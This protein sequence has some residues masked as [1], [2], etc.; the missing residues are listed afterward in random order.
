[1]PPPLPPLQYQP[2]S[3]STANETTPV[4]SLLACDKERDACAMQSG[5]R[6]R[7]PPSTSNKGAATQ[8]THLRCA[9]YP[10][11][12][13]HGSN[14]TQ[15][16]TN[17]VAQSSTNF[18]KS[19]NTTQKSNT[20]AQDNLNAIQ[21]S[22]NIKAVQDNSNDPS[23]NMAQNSLN[24][25]QSSSNCVQS[26]LNS[27]KSVQTSPSTTQNNSYNTHSRTDNNESS[28]DIAQNNSDN[29]NNTDINYSSSEIIQ[30]RSD[31]DQ[32]SFDITENGF[33]IAQSSSNNA[34]FNSNATQ[35]SSN[36]CGTNFQSIS[37]TQNSSFCNS[38]N[39]HN[40]NRSSIN[41]ISSSNVQSNVCYTPNSSSVLQ[42]SSNFSQNSSNCPQSSSNYSQSNSNYS[43]SNSNYSQSSSTNPQSSSNFPQGNSGF[44]S[45]N[46]SQGN[47]SSNFAGSNFTQS[48]TDTSPSNFII[49][50]YQNSPFQASTNFQGGSASGFIQGG[51]F[52][53]NGYVQQNVPHVYL[54]NN[55]HYSSRQAT[56]PPYPQQHCFGMGN[57]YGYGGGIYPCS[58]FYRDGGSQQ[59]ER[60]RGSTEE[61]MTTWSKK[62]HS[63]SNVKGSNSKSTKGMNRGNKGGGCESS[64]S[65]EL[66]R[67]RGLNSIESDRTRGS[68]CTREMKKKIDIC[69]FRSNSVEGLNSTNLN[70]DKL[71]TT[72][73]SNTAR[74]LDLDS[75][76]DQNNSARGGLNATLGG[77]RSV[78][79]SP[80][81]ENENERNHKCDNKSSH[82]DQSVFSGG[83]IKTYNNNRY[84]RGSSQQRLGRGNGRVY[85]NNTQRRLVQSG[86][87]NSSQ[88]LSET[89]TK[90]PC[91]DVLSSA[92]S[93]SPNNLIPDC[94]NT[95]NNANGIA[96]NDELDSKP[97]CVL[98]SRSNMVNS[99][100]KNPEDEM[101]SCVKIKNKNDEDLKNIEYSVV[102][103]KNCIHI[104]N[105][106]EEIKRCIEIKNKEYTDIKNKDSIEIKNKEHV[107]V[108]NKK[109][110]NVEISLDES[111]SENKESIQKLVVNEILKSNQTQQK[112]QNKLTPVLQSNKRLSNLTH[113][114]HNNIVPQ[115]HSASQHFV[116]PS[117]RNRR[118]MRRN[119][120]PLSEIGAGDAPLPNNDVV[121]TVKKLDSLKL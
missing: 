42:L 72:E 76:A 103:N 58:Y 18:A 115:M 1:M 13:I 70:A 45:S 26:G 60:V 48:I 99:N 24:A 9:S 77:T 109:E 79:V 49:S 62:R 54:Q 19:N 52:S 89:N 38:S 94:F 106:D 59:K 104:K 121:D 67:I 112:N 105:K 108:K 65:I 113:P 101:G 85:K 22:T 66:N 33:D 46:F 23:N 71:N 110:T 119:G 6:R 32:N 82:Y 25:T 114:I 102:K 41:T 96:L 111:K 30:N 21:T 95:E 57:L 78:T 84:Y 87:Q 117:R 116:P 63:Y 16:V 98:I 68:S 36:F 69:G 88:N 107:E 100:A 3:S 47:L 39:L 35:S 17:I 64:K 11:S 91:F 44:A 27:F 5:W 34:Q 51:C 4:V 7:T 86:A 29:A 20:G 50:G 81:D 97:N 61:K 28:S 80:F 120:P 75:T 37:Y 31:N 56:T 2:S 92:E 74:F 15:N 83:Y 73:E 55:G 118:S 40:S 43:Q 53:Q 90:P 93:P 10:L 14:F 12:Y 8:E